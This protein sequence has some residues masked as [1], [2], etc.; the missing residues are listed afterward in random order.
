MLLVLREGEGREAKVCTGTAPLDSV[1]DGA[2]S[3]AFRCSPDMLVLDHASSDELPVSAKCFAGAAGARVLLL[4]ALFLSSTTIICI[5]LSPACL[6]LCELAP[7]THTICMFG[8]RASPVVY[9]GVAL[10]SAW[11][12]WVRVACVG[13]SGS[14]CS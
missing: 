1:E 2:S 7:G 13:S 14:T 3:C 8:T 9:T 11:C 4:P 12:T 10:A 5:I 6:G